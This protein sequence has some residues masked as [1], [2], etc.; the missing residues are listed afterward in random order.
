MINKTN[1]GCIN[2]NQL[3]ICM[4][5]CTIAKASCSSQNCNECEVCEND[6]FCKS[7]KTDYE[8]AEDKKSCYK[9]EA[10]ASPSQDQK[11][12]HQNCLNCSDSF[13]NGNMNCICATR[14]TQSHI[15]S[16]SKI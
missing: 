8:M 1:N 13:K 2:L 5:I 10:F 12:C 11:I 14:I 6:W 16:H 9:K 3:R 15:K 7:C 4:F